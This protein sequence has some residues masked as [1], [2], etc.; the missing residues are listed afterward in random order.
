MYNRPEPDYYSAAICR[1]GHVETMR[2]ELKNQKIKA[3]CEKCGTL[4]LTSC[5][6]CEKA[7]QGAPTGAM[8]S[9]PKPDFCT[10]CGS[11][12]PWVSRQAR[13]YQ[14]QNLLDGQEGLSEADRLTIQEQIQALTKSD[15]ADEEQVKRWKM[16]KKA[17]PTV[18]EFGKELI[19]SVTSDLVQKQ[20][21]IK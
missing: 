7:I 5:P 15:I 12:F 1:R 9:Y 2:I 21:G 3:H 17:N 19:I 4:I 8:G 16:I 6:S 11:P 18:F 20:I 14:L 13:L 10:Y